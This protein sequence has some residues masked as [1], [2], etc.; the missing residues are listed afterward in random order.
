MMYQKKGFKVL[1]TDELFLELISKRTKV[2]RLEVHVMAHG[3]NHFVIFL[4]VS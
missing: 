3:V 2:I 1:V 4:C